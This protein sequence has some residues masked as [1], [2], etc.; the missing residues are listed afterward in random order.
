MEESIR[1]PYDSL[2]FM[3]NYTKERDR[4]WGKNFAKKGV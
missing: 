1:S 3:V 2:K 4:K